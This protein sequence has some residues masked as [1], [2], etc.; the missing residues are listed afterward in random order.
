MS[1]TYHHGDLRNAL[2]V[3]ATE[4]LEAHGPAALSLRD[5]ARSAGVSHNAPYRH[6]ANRDA[7]LD[8]IAADGFRA[9]A[10]D[11]RTV[12]GRQPADRLAAMGQAY[13]AA[14]RARPGRFALMFAPPGAPDAFPAT[15]AAA[16]HTYAVLAAAVREVVGRDDPVA[17][18]SAWALAHGLAD[19]ARHALI[20][21]DVA[22]VTTATRRFARS[23]AAS[24]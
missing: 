23:L 15:A 9:L 22:L 4:L 16:Q 5:V 1:A 10:D 3:A 8:A 17:V 18:A 11:M 6:F 7:L 21:A 12:K 13:V 2:L 20:P 24:V 19:L 14:A